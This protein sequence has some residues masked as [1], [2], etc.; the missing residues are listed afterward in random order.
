MAMPPSL[1]RTRI[2]L[3]AVIL[4]VIAAAVTLLLSGAISVSVGVLGGTG[5]PPPQG[6]FHFETDAESVTIVRDVGEEVDAT[7]LE[8]RVDNN[9]LGTWSSL[10][11]GTSTVKH[12]GRLR[13]TNV[14][15]GD[16]VGLYWTGGEQPHRLQ[17]HEVAD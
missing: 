3:L 11:N 5:D 17:H 15:P 4:V 14:D 8:I 2:A 7:K 13:I 12:G 9:T 10:A 6:S 1:S 16:R